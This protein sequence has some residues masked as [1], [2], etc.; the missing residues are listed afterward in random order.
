MIYGLKISGNSDT[1]TEV[2]EYCIK[3]SIHLFQKCSQGLILKKD[4]DVI[5]FLTN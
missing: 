3:N 1:K 4:N 5:Q 2:K